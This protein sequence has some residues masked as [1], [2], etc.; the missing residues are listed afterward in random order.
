MTG[1]GFN[2]C[3]L[4]PWVIASRHF[5]EHPQPLEIQGVRLANRHFFA[6]LETISSAG[7]RAM[8]FNDYMSVK[9]QLHHWQS[10]TDTARK[11]LKN[12]YLRFLRGWMMDAN[13][14]EGAVLKGWVESRI[15]IPPTFHRI[16]IPGIHAEEYMTYAMDRTKGS[17]RTNAINSQLDLL[18]E[19]CQHELALKFPGRLTIPLYRGTYDA[20][21][22]EVLEQLAKREQI[23][24]LNNLVS[25]TSDE[26]RAWEFGS[27]VWEVQVPLAKI[28]FFSDL[29]PSSILKGEGEYMVIGGEYRVKRILCTV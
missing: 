3:N 11:S 1:L 8:I 24:R 15:G 23:V 10:Q 7:E 26:E 28:F 21:E 22:H 2:L 12:S 16:R 25:F 14:V 29:L 6:K 5:N 4:P 20:S 27:T 19:F 17:A 18:Y 9:Y 13:S